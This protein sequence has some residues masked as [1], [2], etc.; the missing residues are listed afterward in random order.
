MLTG[1]HLLVPAMVLCLGGIPASAEALRQSRD[2]EG[3]VHFGTS[4]NPN[5]CCMCMPALRFESERGRTRFFLPYGL[6]RTVGNDRVFSS[7]D[8]KAWYCEGVREMGRSSHK[9]G[10]IPAL[11]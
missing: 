5:L 1:N 11:L 10:L 4:R 3:N 9:C 7:Q 2:T 8:G 6:E